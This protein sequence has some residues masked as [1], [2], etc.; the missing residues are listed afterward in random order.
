MRETAKGL[1]KSPGVYLF[2][3]GRGRVL[4]IGKARSLRSRVLSYF[5]KTPAE[6]KVPLMLEAASQIEHIEAPSEVDALLLENRLIKDIQPK[7]NSQLKDGKS[8][9]Y[10]VIERRSDFPRVF[11][12]RGKDVKNV[13]YYGPFIDATGL[14]RSFKILQKV[15]RF[16]TCTMEISASD[17]KLRYRRPCLLYN[18]G[19]CLGPCGARVSR[20]E[21]RAAI[22]RFRKMLLGKKQVLIRELKNAMRM[23]SASL[24]FEKAAAF[25]DEI[26]ALESLEKMAR[27]GDFVEAETLAIDPK[28]GLGELGKVLGMK[29]AP[30]TIDG[31][32]IATLAGGESVGSIVR[33]VDGAPFKAGYR[34]YKIKTVEG[35][36]DYAMMR[37]VVRRRFK[38]IEKGEEEA[39]DVMLVDGGKG[40]LSS[41]LGVINNFH[42]TPEMVVSLA[43]REEEIYLSGKKE[44]IRLK[45][46]NAALRLLMYV[47]DE[48]HRFAQHYHHLLRKKSR[49]PKRARYYPC[50]CQSGS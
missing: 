33:F 4:Y 44:P 50:L 12:I 24:E 9:P 15:F 43:K 49:L 22:E 36:D 37:E 30:R 47:R 38:R 27:Y 39:P 7:Y 18:V 41:V 46:S 48:S 42:E 10:V 40:Q 45:K 6:A 3:D 11:I 28:K 5:N 31:I 35:V 14:R 13:T 25:R 29:A 26:Q 32:D 16:R 1:P 19:Y 21:Y 17:K 2:K 20:E 8:Y 34:R 23:A